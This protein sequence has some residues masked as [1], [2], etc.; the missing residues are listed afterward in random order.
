MFADPKLAAAVAQRQLTLL[1]VY[2]EGNAARWRE[3]LDEFP[4]GWTIG[5]DVTETVRRTMLYDLKA[6]PTVYLMD[7]QH[8]VLKKDA[9]Y[10]ACL[11]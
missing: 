9:P 4:A 5:N 1:A 8:V 7:A 2:T 3:T 11:E 10:E 6:M